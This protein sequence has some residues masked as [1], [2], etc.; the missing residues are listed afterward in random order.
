MD[1]LTLAKVAL[2]I[3][4]VGVFAFGVRSEETVIR[5]VGIGLVIVAFLLR[6]VK[7]RPVE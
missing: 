7:K 1:R 3:V 4:G 2:V 5:W 6:F